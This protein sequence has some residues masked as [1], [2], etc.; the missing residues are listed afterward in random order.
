MCIGAVAK[1]AMASETAIGLSIGTHVLAR[2]TGISVAEGNSDASRCACLIGKKSHDSPQISRTG[3]SNRG[4]A[5][6]ASMRSC[7]RKPAMAATR[8]SATRRSRRAGPKNDSV[9]SW[10]SSFA[11]TPEAILRRPRDDRSWSRSSARVSRGSVRDNAAAFLSGQRQQQQSTGHVVGDHC[12]I[13]HLEQLERV[14][15]QLSQRGGGS[16]RSCG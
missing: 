3:R 14:E 1:A 5:C 9:R 6:A 8:S 2:G 16:I 4:I 7:G 13:L 10:P 15:Q 12:R 11:A